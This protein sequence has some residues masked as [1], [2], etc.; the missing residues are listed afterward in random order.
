MKIITLFLFVLLQETTRPE[1]ADYLRESG[2]IYVVISV[3]V[4]IFI[5]IILFLISQEIRLKKLEKKFKE[6]N[7]N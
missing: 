5:G 6:K 7:S 1:M 4:T 3:L 2:K